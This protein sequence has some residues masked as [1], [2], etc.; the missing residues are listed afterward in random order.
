ML[1]LTKRTQKNIEALIGESFDDIC[2]MDS[3]K[4][5]G[6]CMVFSRNEPYSVTRGNP[7]LAEGRFT[8][9]EESDRYMLKLIRESRRGR[10]TNK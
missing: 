10:K 9:I 8:T 3:N 5:N 1:E 6:I 7:Y 4:G 2:D